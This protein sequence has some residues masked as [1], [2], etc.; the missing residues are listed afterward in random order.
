[1]ALISTVASVVLTI[2]YLYRK[3]DHAEEL[4]VQITQV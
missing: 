1:L 2:W 3:I 4:H